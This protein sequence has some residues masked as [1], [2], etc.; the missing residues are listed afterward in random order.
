M[1]RPRWVSSASESTSRA[2]SSSSADHP[3]GLLDQRRGRSCCPRQQQ[4][5]LL[6]QLGDVS[7]SAG[8]PEMAISLPRTWIGVEGRSIEAQQLVLGP[9]QRHHRVLAR[10]RRAR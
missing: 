3:D 2:L 1:V 4:H 5:E 10:A 8:S 9:E 6:E 7:T